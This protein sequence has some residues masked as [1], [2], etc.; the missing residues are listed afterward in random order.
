M[1][2]VSRD[3]P[4]P[5][6]VSLAG[7]AEFVEIRGERDVHQGAVEAGF[8]VPEGEFKGEEGGGQVFLLG[9]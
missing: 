5:T 6:G 3:M 8:A 7:A 2:R 9:S 1:H 4:R